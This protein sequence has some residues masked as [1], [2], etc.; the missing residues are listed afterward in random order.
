ME[1]VDIVHWRVEE[2]VGLD[3]I[4]DCVCRANIHVG[5]HKGGRDDG[6]NEVEEQQPE[7][8]KEDEK[9]EVGTEG[10]GAADHLLVVIRIRVALNDHAEE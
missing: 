6:K 7:E 10:V 8:T 4:D 9:E 5:V 2:N 3:D 1:A